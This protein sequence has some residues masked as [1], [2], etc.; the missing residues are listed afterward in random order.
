[1]THNYASTGAGTFVNTLS[2]KIRLDNNEKYDLTASIAVDWDEVSEE[3]RSSIKSLDVRFALVD[4]EQFLVMEC[5]IDKC[6]SMKNYA[7]ENSPI[8]SNST[9]IKY[10]PA[11]YNGYVLYKED[12]FQDKEF[13]V[14]DT[15]RTRILDGWKIIMYV[16]SPNL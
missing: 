9:Y 1:V 15:L 2:Q 12:T 7:L 14:Y 13:H 11:S 4:R 5:T 8:T 16:K 10:N 3:I 6:N